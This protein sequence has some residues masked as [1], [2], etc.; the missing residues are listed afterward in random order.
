MLTTHR[1]RLL[2]RTVELHYAD[3][4]IGRTLADELVLY[5]KAADSEETDLVIRFGPLPPSL[6]QS[7]NPSVHTEHP[8]GFVA[9]YTMAT[10]DYRFGEDRLRSVDLQI[11]VPE[12]R[13]WKHVQRFADMQFTSREMRAGMILHELALVPA[14]ALDPEAFPVHASALEA[15][16]G[17]VILFGGTGGV[18]KTS[19]CLEL[20]LNAGYRFVADDIAVLGPEGRAFP[21]LAYPKIY[22]YNLSGNSPLHTAVF[23]DRGTLDRLHW[24]LHRLRGPDKV[25]RRASP[26]VLYGEHSRDGGPVKRYVILARTHRPDIRLDAVSPDE[27][28]S[29]SV[30]VLEAELSTFLNHVRWH[31]YNRRLSN[32]E[33]LVHPATLVA[34]WESGL[35][36]AL[37]DT[38]CFV[39]RIPVGMEHKAFKQA[40][41]QALAN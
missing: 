22:G 33:A 19:L 21:N 34:R 25:R 15:P 35:T 13:L 31:M 37:R 26:E 5:P 40:M 24:H 6:P 3:D 9:R 30:P 8:E 27:A 16:D 14:A 1:L 2:G 11:N 23:T 17:S 7:T 36:R 41:R 32:Q 12:S 4:L 20:C 18:G 39:A 29:L 38:E 28:A 10:V